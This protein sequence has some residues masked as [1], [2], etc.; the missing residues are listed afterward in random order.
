MNH[1]TTGKDAGSRGLHLVGYHWPA[2]Y[3]VD[4]DSLALHHKA[5]AWQA[6]HQTDYLTAVRAVAP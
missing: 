4:A 3:R 1:V 6:R 5:L 2:G